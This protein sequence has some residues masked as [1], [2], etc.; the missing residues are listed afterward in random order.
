MHAPL[1]SRVPSAPS[2]HA[3]HTRVSSIQFA[4]NRQCLLVPWKLSHQ[5]LQKIT[6]RHIC[7]HVMVDQAD[8]ML[9]CE[10]ARLRSLGVSHR[11]GGG[12]AGHGLLGARDII[13]RRGLGERRGVEVMRQEKLDP[14]HDCGRKWSGKDG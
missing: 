6:L 5:E 8:S 1:P 2:V 11:R 14:A 13:R 7:V 9:W 10:S 4:P 12:A 3:L